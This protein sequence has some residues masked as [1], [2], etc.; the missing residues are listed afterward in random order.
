MEKIKLKAL[1]VNAGF[2]QGETAK[3]LGISQKTLSNWENG[4]TF[5]DQRA[6]EKIC[7][8][9][10]VSYDSINFDV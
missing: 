8:F 3:E 4:I 7:R 9:F 2:T 6:I 1:R 5:P 10:G